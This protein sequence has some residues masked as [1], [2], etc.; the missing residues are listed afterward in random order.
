MVK[1][2]GDFLGDFFSDTVFVRRFMKVYDMVCFGV[3]LYVFGQ[4]R[5]GL[6]AEGSVGVKQDGSRVERLT[7][8]VP[9][10][11]FCSKGV[12]GWNGFVVGEG[13]GIVE[14]V[15]KDGCRRKGIEADRVSEVW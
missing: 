4:S 10:E 8:I 14:D 1:M 2:G 5:L 12:E 11:L 15:E 13:Y 9:K 6:N 3:P 7:F